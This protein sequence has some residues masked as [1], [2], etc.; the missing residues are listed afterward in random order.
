MIR[1]ARARRPGVLVVED[2]AFM[3]A[4]IVDLLERSGEFRVVAEA[5]TGYEAI[6]RLHEAE[7]DLVTL[8]LHMPDLG[9]LETLGYIMSEAPRPVVI[10]SAHAAAE[11]TMQALDFGAVDFVPK[12]AEGD[13]RGLEEMS[14]RLLGAMRAAA[15]AQI[16]N[17]PLLMRR[18]GAVGRTA[19]TPEQ[20]DAATN[21][22]AVAASTGGPRALAD[23][24]PRLPASLAAAVIVVQHMPAGFT[25]S[26]AARLD[27][28]SALPVVEATGGEAIR[29]GHVY[30]ARG[31][32]HLLVRRGA[33]GLHLAADD[34]A[35]VWGVRPAAD[36]LFRSVASHFGP[37]SVGVVLTGMGRDGAE[38]LRVIREVGG[39]TLAQDQA[40]SV[41]YGM[42]RAAAPFAQEILPLEALAEAVAER[43]DAIAR[44]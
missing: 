23:L 8:D 34:S 3:R 37:R 9:G 11:T 1:G 27:A 30:I 35:P 20:G 36:P 24:V 41:I 12:P 33:D 32:R 2:S 42:P 44:M 10:I 25:A 43:V 26:F 39:A 18:G 6:R 14:T 19:R 5:A 17:L 13:E 40:T 21:V 31:G 16:S 38:G 4:V 29:T 15:V 28:S 22:V 7:P